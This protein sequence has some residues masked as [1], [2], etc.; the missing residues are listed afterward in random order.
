VGGCGSLA[1]ARESV[2]PGVLRVLRVLPPGNFNLEP[3]D[4][5]K[6]RGRQGAAVVAGE[7]ARALKAQQIRRPQ[8]HLG[9]KHRCVA[10]VC[11][12]RGGFGLGYKAGVQPLPF[13]PLAC[14]GGG[15]RT[16]TPVREA[17]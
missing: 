1:L 3:F 6:N 11:R 7:Q 5:S 4:D 10:L 9:G 17:D 8:G 13:K 2:M 12:L 15:T 16:H 14:R